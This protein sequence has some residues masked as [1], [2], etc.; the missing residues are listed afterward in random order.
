MWIGLVKH[1]SFSSSFS[2]KVERFLLLEYIHLCILKIDEHE[3]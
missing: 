2:L 1:T 3:M